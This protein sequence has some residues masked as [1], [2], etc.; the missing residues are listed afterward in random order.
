[1]RTHAVF[2]R[3][4]CCVQKTSDTKFADY[5][6]HVAFWFP[7]QG[8]Q[9]V[10]M[11]K[12][13]WLCQHGQRSSSNYQLELQSNSHLLYGICKTLNLC[14]IQDVVNE[15]AAAKD[16]FQQASDILSYDL[17]KVC[18][19][20]MPAQ[21]ASHGQHA[22]QVCT[23]AIIQSRLQAHNNFVFYLQDPKTS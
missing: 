18:T 11:A 8:A 15:V 14:C 13:G 1:M 7:G 23:L 22:P 6:P 2:A 21:Q 12:V 10:G 16:L 5:K 4:L 3:V 19:E 9:T 17:L 20:G